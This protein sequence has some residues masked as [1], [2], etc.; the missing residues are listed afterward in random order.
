MPIR[1]QESIVPNAD[2]ELTFGAISVGAVADGALPLD[3]APS[4]M[5]GYDSA[6]ITVSALAASAT[7]TVELIT[8][9][10]ATGPWT[11]VPG[12]T[13][14][15]INQRISWLVH[16]ESLAERFVSVRWGKTGG[17]A[18]AAGAAAC[19]TK[20]DPVRVDA[21]TPGGGFDFIVDSL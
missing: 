19:I 4:D 12:S 11:V 3:M 5:A 17:T 1:S 9:P 21:R 6:V 13:M 14:G 18:T 15:P 20:L 7:L 8:A 2:G 10:T 16:A